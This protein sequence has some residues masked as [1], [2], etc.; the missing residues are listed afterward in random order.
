M[1]KSKYSEHQVVGAPTRAEA[2]V[3]MKYL[4][5]ERGTGSATFN[6]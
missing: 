6:Q 2:G 4:C 5:R 3:P 1:R